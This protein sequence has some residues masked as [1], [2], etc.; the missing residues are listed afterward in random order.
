MAAGPAHAGQGDPRLGR[1]GAGGRR[2]PLCPRCRR[3]RAPPGRVIG[4]RTGRRATAP[5]GPP[6]APSEPPPV[7]QRTEDRPARQTAPVPDSLD[8]ELATLTDEGPVP[9]E[10]T[11]PAAA[12][13][14][15]GSDRR[16]TC[17]SGTRRTST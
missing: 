2:R 3:F 6:R 13:P 14:R 17:S 10:S 12:P 9:T 8:A 15:D 1:G 4:R 16:W 5:A 11:L 7:P